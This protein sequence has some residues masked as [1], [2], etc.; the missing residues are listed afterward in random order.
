MEPGTAGDA[1]LG[2]H[3][4][5][6]SSAP[7]TRWSSRWPTA[8]SSRSCRVRS[9]ARCR[10]SIPVRMSTTPERAWT[11]PTRPTPATP[12]TRR[13]G[14]AEPDAGDPADFDTAAVRAATSTARRPTIPTQGRRDTGSGEQRHP[15]G[16]LSRA[17][18]L[19]ARPRGERPTAAGRAVQTTATET[20]THLAPTRTR[21]GRQ[22][23][24]LADPLP[25]APRR[26][27]RDERLDAEARAGP[28]WWQSDHPVGAGA[29]HAQTR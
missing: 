15:R 21:P 14:P 1:H 29:G 2:D 17:G 28:A 18:G 8:C 5:A 23:I 19:T 26:D 6:A 4:D 7:R 13:S 9:P 16:S 11:Q 24:V 25:P 20:R 12:I 10:R 27:D 22:L 3:R